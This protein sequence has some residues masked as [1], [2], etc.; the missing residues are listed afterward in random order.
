MADGSCDGG[1]DDG[2]EVKGGIVATSQAVLEYLLRF[3][4]L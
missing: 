1:G 3:D 2:V 4:G